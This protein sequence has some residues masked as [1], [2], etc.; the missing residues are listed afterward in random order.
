ME[1]EHIFIPPIFVHAGN[2]SAN[3]LEGF[4]SIKVA[5]INL[6]TEIVENIILLTSM[7]DPAPENYKFVEVPSKSDVDDEE[8]L[9]LQSI[10]KDIDPNYVPPPIQMIE[11]FIKIGETKWNEEKGFYGDGV[12]F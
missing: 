2:P 3:F 6:D 1:E 11:R 10:L 8:N 9:A 4:K 12:Q 5:M 7:D